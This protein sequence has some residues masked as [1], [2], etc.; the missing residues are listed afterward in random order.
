MRIHKR[1]LFDDI[2]VFEAFQTFIQ[3]K[4]NR[5]LSG[6][7]IE[8]YRLAFTI[9]SK[10]MSIIPEQN[11]K[12]LSEE[13]LEAYI[14]QMQLLGK[15]TSSINH[16]V[17]TLRVFLYWCMKSGYIEEFEIKLMKEQ[18]KPIKIYTDEQLKMLTQ[19][20]QA[21]DD[22]PTYRSYVITCFILATGARAST[23]C[24]IKLEDID[25][26]NGEVIYRHLK[27]KHL[28]IIPIPD[29]L[30]RIIKEYIKV[31]DLS[32]SEYLFCNT[33][34]TPLNPHALW[35]SLRAYNIR[36]GVPALGIHALRHSFA[37]GWIVNG[38]GAFQLQRMLTHST[39]DMTK[40][41]VALFADD[42]K[43]NLDTVCPLNS[44][45]TDRT[46]K[47]NRCI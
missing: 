12:T 30:I 44:Y 26:D 34:A 43:D 17:G 40:K 16:Y 22:F 32:S 33:C 23:V 36:C 46:W 42:L 45:T 9:F 1:V 24:N 31:W 38:G 19:K 41:Y 20:P 10:T 11:V 29:T 8:D 25:L 28:A 21:S 6:E 15:T 4:S 35:E 7:T 18:E 27:N 5:G 14:D 37:R 13:L 47:I 39:L 3:E 2:S